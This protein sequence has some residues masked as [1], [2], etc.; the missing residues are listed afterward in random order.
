LLISYDPI[1][2]ANLRTNL[3]YSKIIDLSNER[4]FT[5]DVCWTQ[6]YSFLLTPA[7]GITAQ[8]YQNGSLITSAP[9]NYNG[10]LSVSIM[11]E[12]TSPNS[13]VNNDIAINVFASAGDDFEVAVPVNTFKLY[14]YLPPAG[15]A[16]QSGDIEGNAPTS[17]SPEQN[18][19]IM[20]MA[21]E[22]VGEVL[23]DDNTLDVY[24]GESITSFRQMLKRYMV[25]TVYPVLGVDNTL[26]NIDEFDFPVY[27]GFGPDARHVVT[28]PVNANI[29]NTTLINYLTPA[30]FAYRGSMRSKYVLFNGG[31]G[32]ST[33][34]VVR[35]NTTA[36]FAVGTI[37]PDSTNAGKFA[38][39]YLS[40]YPDGFP[41]RELTQT[42][43]QPAVDVELPFYS[44]LRFFQ[45]RNF[46][47][48]VN[49]AFRDLMHTV[50]I[51]VAPYSTSKPY[52]ERHVSVGEDFQLILFQGQPPILPSVTL[53][54]T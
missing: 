12:L 41:G 13:S 39:T 8:N 46:S 43:I 50:T 23:Q 42:A 51:L 36:N 45:A 24:F 2:S 38:S 17:D 6:P 44:Y 25:H 1:A 54:P 40:P 16:P 37:L 21:K 22:C 15:V 35:N 10:T 30:F 28:G 31:S 3:Q 7:L 48:T 26:T 5:I 49:T 53:T 29:V 33:L 11:N 32:G 19:P 20:E 14:S 47:R 52:I 34:S 18:A 4:D 27:R 9:F